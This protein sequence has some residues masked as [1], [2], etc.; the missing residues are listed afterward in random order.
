MGLGPL[1]ISLLLLS[2]SRSLTDLSG[3][4][5]SARTLTGNKVVTTVTVMT[6][7]KMVT[8]TRQMAMTTKQNLFAAKPISHRLPVKSLLELLLSGAGS[9]DEHYDH[10]HHYHGHHHHVCNICN[11]HICHET[12]VTYTNIKA[13]K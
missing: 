8:M 1:P 12:Q 3:D 11:F 6:M 7:M 10:H 13:C 9:D 4:L 2:L 5:L